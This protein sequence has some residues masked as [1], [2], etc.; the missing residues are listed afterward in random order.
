[1]CINISRHASG[2]DNEGHARPRR[3]YV[4]PGKYVLPLVSPEDMGMQPPRGMLFVTLVEASDVRASAA[5]AAG[6][7]SPWRVTY[8][9]RPCLVGV[10]SHAVTVS[11][12]RHR[13][14]RGAP[15]CLP[16]VRPVSLVSK[17]YFLSCSA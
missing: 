11:G 13:F 1:M 8:P 4:L 15:I 3:P 14:T 17:T 6:F 7:A 10:P 9:A 2:A 5:C 16:Y 12:L